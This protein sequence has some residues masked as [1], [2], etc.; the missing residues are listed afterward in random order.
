MTLQY[1]EA[2]KDLGASPSTKF[3]IPLEFTEMG[4]MLG[5]YVNKGMEDA[6]EGGA[7][8]ARPARPAAPAAPAGA[9]GET[10]TGGAPGT[11][12]GPGGST[13]PGTRSSS[14]GDWTPG[15]D[16]SLG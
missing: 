13:G 1:L 10:P 14:A 2:L 5:R 12:G 15:A 16:R 3:V 11:L 9:P 4:R 8:A 7:A 6:G